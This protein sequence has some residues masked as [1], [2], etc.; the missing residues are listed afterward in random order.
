MNEW[1]KVLQ[2]YN[3]EEILETADLT[4]EEVLEILEGQGIF[5]PTFILGVDH[6]IP[7]E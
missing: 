2:E 5:F 7:Q 3:L 6:D 1:S 4:Q